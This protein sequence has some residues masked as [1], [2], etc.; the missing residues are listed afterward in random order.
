M[1][2]ALGCTSAAVSATSDTKHK[3]QVNT[4]YSSLFLPAS[5]IFPHG[6]KHLPDTG[7][8]GTVTTVFKT[9]G[10]LIVWSSPCHIN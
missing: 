4:F 5:N 6:D 9:K 7:A 8:L 10:L 3:L 2:L 1:A